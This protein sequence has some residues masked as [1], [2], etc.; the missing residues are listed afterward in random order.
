[1]KARH[2][3]SFFNY[4]LE[5]DEPLCLSKCNRIRDDAFLLRGVD[6]RQKFGFSIWITTKVV[7]DRSQGGGGSVAASKSISMLLVNALL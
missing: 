1:M 4:C 3:E 7:E 6:F 5:V 2:T